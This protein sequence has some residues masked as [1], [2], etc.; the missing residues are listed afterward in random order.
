MY[1]FM[2]GYIIILF[3]GKELSICT[4]FAMK[5][6]DEV[7]AEQKL[8][9]KYKGRVLVLVPLV[10]SFTLVFFLKQP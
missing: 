6:S 9:A 3:L 10:Y 7:R 4:V 1:I 2:L 5:P 8:T